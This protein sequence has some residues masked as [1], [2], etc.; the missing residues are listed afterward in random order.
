MGDTIPFFYYDILSRIIPGGLT[1]GVLAWV[2]VK[3][4][5]FWEKLRSPGQE[6]WRTVVVPLVYLGAAYC[7][8]LLIEA[9]SDFPGISRA[10]NKLMD[11]AFY[12]AWKQYE[13]PVRFA[14]AGQ[15]EDRSRRQTLRFWAWE[16][17]VFGS[18][19]SMFSLAHRFQTEMKLFFHSIPACLVLAIAPLLK[20]E[21]SACMKTPLWLVVA[22]LMLLAAYVREKRRWIQVLAS[23]NHPR[24]IP[25]ALA[26]SDE[27]P[28]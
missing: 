24:V 12:K 7:V 18:S 22:S 26:S 11:Y 2:G 1:L 20:R 25:S 5:E 14:D 15:F 23:V 27:K 10:T 8:G 16:Q 9:I 13:T 17:V 28:R 21:P 3:A 4:P 6:G 19:P